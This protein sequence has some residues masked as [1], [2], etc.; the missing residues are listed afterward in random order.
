VHD[1]DKIRHLQVGSGTAQPMLEI[2]H[3][4]HRRLSYGKGEREPQDTTRRSTSQVPMSV[5]KN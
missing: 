2:M 3:K 5:G 1:G 4:A